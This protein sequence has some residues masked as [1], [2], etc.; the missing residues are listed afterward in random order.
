M[1]SADGAAVR[2]SMTVGTRADAFDPEGGRLAVVTDERDDNGDGIAEVEIAE[3]VGRIN[4]DL[5]VGAD[6][7]QASPLV[8]NSDLSCPG[9]KLH[10]A[11]FI[12]ISGGC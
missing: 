3:Y 6:V 12:V 5:T 2:V 8:A 11:G 4:A 10:G 7:T 9:V 1:D